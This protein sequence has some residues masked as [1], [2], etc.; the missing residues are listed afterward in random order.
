MEILVRTGNQREILRERDKRM[1]T[2]KIY[3]WQWND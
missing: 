2:G 1:E 3:D